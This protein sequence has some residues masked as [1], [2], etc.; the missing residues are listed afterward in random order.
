MQSEA[1]NS[2]AETDQ[3]AAD[4]P[5]PLHQ[6]LIHAVVD[7]AHLAADGCVAFLK[8]IGWGSNR[9]PKD[10]SRQLSLNLALK[11]GAMMR[12]AQWHRAGLDEYLDGEIQRKLP[13]IILRTA[14]YRAKPLST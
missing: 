11:I 7:E 8:V 10:D 2:H 6:R 12:L 14:K 5:T 3:S 13:R 9:G 1:Y 4:P